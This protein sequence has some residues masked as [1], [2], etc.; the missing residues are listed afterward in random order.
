MAALPPREGI[1]HQF[2]YMGKNIL[3]V[4]WNKKRRM[5]TYLTPLETRVSFRWCWASERSPGVSLPVGGGHPPVQ[6]GIYVWPWVEGHQAAEMA[7]CSGYGCGVCARLVG[8]GSVTGLLPIAEPSTGSPVS[9]GGRMAHG[10]TGTVWGVSD[11]SRQRSVTLMRQEC[12][13]P[14]V[15]C[16]YGFGGVFWQITFWPLK[17]KYKT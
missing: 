13:C 12:V 1:A 10:C 9:D 11:T 17:Q 7:L 2:L 16:A 4:K 3:L 5:N 14:C 15:T 8:C 6:S